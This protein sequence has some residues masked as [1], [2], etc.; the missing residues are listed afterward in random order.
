M[1]VVIV[2][3]Q[4]NMRNLK[5]TIEEAN[6]KICEMIILSLSG[7]LS[8]YLYGDLEPDYFRRFYNLNNRVKE[9]Y[10]FTNYT[11]RIQKYTE[12]AIE[13]IDMFEV[14]L[15]DNYANVTIQFSGDESDVSMTFELKSE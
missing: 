14:I 9:I 3:M 6:E 15:A 10:S 11:A 4:I 1:F 12:I 8:D 2:R 13:Y 7:I 5:I